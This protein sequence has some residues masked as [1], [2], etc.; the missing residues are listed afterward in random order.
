MRDVLGH[1]LMVGADR[2]TPVDETLIPTGELPEVTGTPFDFRTPQRVGEALLRHA[3][4]EQL[5]FAGGYDHNFVLRSGDTPAVRLH[6]PE[7][8]RTL[9]VET[10]EPG[11]QVYSGNF[12]DG[13][14]RGK[15]G[16]VYARHWGLCLETQHFPD[17]PHQPQFPSVVLRPETPFESRTRFAFGVI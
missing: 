17:S 2:Y 16:R 12:L 13:S 1:E 11:V 3:A 14:V 5:R 4:S 6:D 7:S 10:T 15:G 9:T 8:G